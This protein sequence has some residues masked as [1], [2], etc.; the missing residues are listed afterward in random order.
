MINREK[1]LTIFIT[2]QCNLDC[3]YCFINKSSEKL[4]WNKYH[5]KLIESFILEYDYT[6]IQ[7]VW[8]EPLLNF[9]Y[10]IKI[11]F[12]I[13]YLRNKYKNKYIAISDIV[14]NWTIYNSF[15][16]QFLNDNNIWLEF[17]IDRFL[18]EKVD[19]NRI[20]KYIQWYKLYEVIEKNFK[21]YIK[22]FWKS[23]HISLVI[24]NDNVWDLFEIVNFFIK[25]L[26]AKYITICTIKWEEW[27]ID[28]SFSYVFKKEYYKI[29]HYFFNYWYK[30][31]ILIDPI[32]NIINELNVAKFNWFSE[33]TWFGD[34]IY[35]SYNGYVYLNEKLSAKWLNNDL[36]WS[37]ELWI[38]FNKINLK[39]REIALNY[40]YSDIQFLLWVTYWY[41][42]EYKT[43]NNKINNILYKMP[44]LFFKE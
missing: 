29:C 18:Y 41:E 31:W 17:S 24:T 25:Q 21:K 34:I 39:N 38:D 42:D 11:I 44:L 26:N 5:E 10:I 23:P 8:W 9:D 15:Y 19:K 35:L 43:L 20:H 1:T 30:E 6:R 7:I 36:F 27:F 13:K 3:K 40:N 28:E 22:I 37:I 32:F 2:N 16:Y 14:T 33:K 4:I 12:Y